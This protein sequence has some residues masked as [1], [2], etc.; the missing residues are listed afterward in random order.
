M[1]LAAV[2]VAGRPA[3]EPE[4]EELEHHPEAVAAGVTGSGQ[5]PVA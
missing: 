5:P 1:V 2:W 4:V 3:R